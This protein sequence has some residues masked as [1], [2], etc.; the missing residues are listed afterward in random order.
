MGMIDSLLGDSPRRH[1]RRRGYYVFRKVFP[2][3]QIDALAD[4]ARNMMPAYQGEHLRQN[5]RA[6]ANDFYSGTQLIR[7]PPFNLHLPLSS[8]LRPLSVA[9]QAL[10]TAPAL[11]DRLRELDGAERYHINQ[12]LLFFAAQTT[13][14]HLDSWAL[15]TVPHGGAHTLWIPLQDMDFK[16]GLPSILPWP[17]GKLVSERELGLSSDRSHADRYAR[18]HEALSAKL[19]EDGPEIAAAL[20]RRGD[21]MVWSSLTPH[22][23]LPSQPSPAERLSLQVLVRPAHLK[24]G[25]FT[26]QPADHPSTRVLPASDQFSFF[27]TE[28][29]HRDF[30]IG[31][32][33]PR[34]T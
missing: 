23:T 11:A 19:L 12:T 4:T 32:M 3:E 2:V 15:D 10:I 31:E 34:A 13:G 1:Y 22:F 21:L 25:S 29:I 6:E 14:F 20:V 30:G 24:W 17:L 9:L 28:D 18:Y 7:N 8:D 33:L 26:V 5:G 16:S 27:V